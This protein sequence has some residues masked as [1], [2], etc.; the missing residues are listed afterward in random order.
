MG[1]IFKETHKTIHLNFDSFQL[2]VLSQILI[3][4]LFWL[5]ICL[6]EFPISVFSILLLLSSPW[7]FLLYFLTLLPLVIP[8]S[9]L[10]PSH[11]LVF[12]P[13]IK[14]STSIP[15]AHLRLPRKVIQTRASLIIYVAIT[16]KFTTLS[17]SIWLCRNFTLFFMNR[18][19]QHARSWTYHFPQLKHFEEKKNHFEILYTPW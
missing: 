4:I 1:N 6:I 7:T 16:Q 18:Q 11:Q 2:A 19:I 8:L 12:Y 3:T 10:A 9:S 17:S 15:L 13:W 5:S 14:C